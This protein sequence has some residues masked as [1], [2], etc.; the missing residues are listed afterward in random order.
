M[1]ITEVLHIRLHAS[2]KVN[3]ICL[4]N[5]CFAE[6]RECLQSSQRCTVGTV[7]ELTIRFEQSTSEHAKFVKVLERVLLCECKVLHAID[8]E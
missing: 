3:R 7:E 5:T 2:R 6:F 4:Q 8:G 1:A